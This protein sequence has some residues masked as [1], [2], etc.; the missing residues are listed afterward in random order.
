MITQLRFFLADYKRMAG[1]N[2]IRYLYIWLTRPF[3]AIG[4]YR[5]ERG[6]FLTLGKGWQ[7]IRIILLPILNLL[8]AYGNSEINYHANIGPGLLILHSSLGNVVSG[9]S[10]IGGNLTLT[11]GNVI[12]NRKPKEDVSIVIGKN[13]TMGAHA[14]ILG[15]VVMGNNIKIAACACVVKDAHDN[16]ILLGVPA[17]DISQSRHH[18]ASI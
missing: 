8:Y 18:I 11:G 1:N 14:V 10:N 7:Y 17:K 15:P 13:C 4:L 12:G 5:F 2:K 9:K 16:A 3:V 6:M